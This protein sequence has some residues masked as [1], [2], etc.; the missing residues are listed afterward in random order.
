[1]KLRVDS[2]ACIGCGLCVGTYPDAFEF[3]DE[4]KARVIAEID[5]ASGEDAMGSCPVG[6]IEAE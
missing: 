1:M 5:D 4:G 3:D 2:D 6:A